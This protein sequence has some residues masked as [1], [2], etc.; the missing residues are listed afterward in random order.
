MARALRLEEPGGIYHVAARGN[1]GGT[2]YGDNADRHRFFELFDRV[3]RR[4][5][6]RCLTYCLMANHFHLVLRV[7]DGGL[8]AGMQYLLSGYARAT[9]KRYG[10]RDHLFR[11]HF[12][13]VRLERDAHL[14]EAL[15]YAVLNPVCAP[16]SASCPSSGCG[17]ATAPAWA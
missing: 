3:V 8:S 11:Q 12:F 2:I 13:S 6:W 14:R 1:S 7:P 17:A 15:R 10:R 5:H 16:V 4:H 9:N